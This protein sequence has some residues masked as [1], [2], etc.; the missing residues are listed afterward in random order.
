MQLELGRVTWRLRLQ[1]FVRIFPEVF[2][3]HLDALKSVDLRYSNGFS[4]YWQQSRKP[5]N[6]P[7]RGAARN[8]RTHVKED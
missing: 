7:Q 4:V 5:A 3:G 2:A 8:A 1:R 6:A